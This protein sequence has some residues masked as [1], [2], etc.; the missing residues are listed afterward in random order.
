MY[1]YG[2]I[3]RQIAHYIQSQMSEYPSVTL[4][5][6]RQCG[7][8][9]LVR[10]LFPDF[11]YANLED[12]TTRELAS[13]DPDE[14]FTR[15]PAPV[16]ID[17][18][19]RVPSLLGQVQ[20]RID[21]NHAKGQFLLTGSNQISVKASVAQSLA[22]RTAII[23]MLPLS[24]AEIENSGISLERDEQI[25]AGGMPFLFAE[26]GHSPFDYY[27]NYVNTYV[28]RDIAQ[29][30]SVRDLS[31]FFSFLKLLAGRTGQL[32]NS[33]AIGAEVGVSGNT[34]SAWLSLL[35][36]SHIVYILKPWFTSRTSQVVKSPKV[37]FCDTGLASYLL[38][39]ETTAQLQRDPMLGKLFENLVVLEALKCRLNQGCEPNL[40]FFRNSNGLEVDLLLS[41]KHGLDIF[42]IK[43]GKAFNSDFGKPMKSFA[44]KYAEHDSG[45]LP[46]VIYSGQN[47]DSFMDVRY[48]NFKG[49]DK[50]FDEK[51]NRFRIQF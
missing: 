14:F 2:M 47:A 15:F 29:E 10:A 7:K 1:I 34:V 21:R 48:A 35:E 22:G 19:H 46:T 6:P 45:N 24:I 38:G 26:S 41:R 13:K 17:E 25:L 23:D 44:A 27:R 3:E 18:I 42:E 39:I 12:F 28:E 4:F 36:A 50:L 30:A 11:A 33:A 32:M 51:E 43:S 8:T 40:F 16:I 31:K 49:I 20:V 37:Y 9:T 5:G